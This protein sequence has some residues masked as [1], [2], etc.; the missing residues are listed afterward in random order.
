MPYFCQLNGKFWQQFGKKW[1]CRVDQ[2]SNP[3]IQLNAKNSK[4]I[5][6]G[7]CWKRLD[8]YLFN[9]YYS[10]KKFQDGEDHEPSSYLQKFSRQF[11]RHD[12]EFSHFSRQFSRHDSEFSHQIRHLLDDEH[13]KQS[14]G[15]KIP[16]IVLTE[17]GQE[18][19]RWA[20]L[21]VQNFTTRW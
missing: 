9:W 5:L 16:D 17:E 11:S 1:T 19:N 14:N 20:N 21:L 8:F 3:V 13:N 6:K 18:Q 2:W 10:L 12:S 4:P 15:T 7:I